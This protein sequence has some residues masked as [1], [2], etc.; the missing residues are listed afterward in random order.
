[1]LSAKIRLCVKHLKS[2]ILQ[3]SQEIFLAT[4]TYLSTVITMPCSKSAGSHKLFR[5]WHY[6]RFVFG[7]SRPYFEK[8]EIS[9]TIPAKPD[10][11]EDPNSSQRRPT[12]TPTSETPIEIG[13]KDKEKK[14]FTSKPFN[15][16]IEISLSNEHLKKY[17]FDY[18]VIYLN[19]HRIQ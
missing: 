10:Q 5:N 18:N 13:R 15:E 9:E 11:A 7:N 1:M 4:P 16:I 12:K 8:L 3:K 14:Q 2:S 6:Y 17:I 19:A